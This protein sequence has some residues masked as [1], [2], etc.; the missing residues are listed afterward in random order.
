MPLVQVKGNQCP[1]CLDENLNWNLKIENSDMFMFGCG[2][3]CCKTCFPKLK[4]KEAF[5]CPCCREDGHHTTIS[6]LGGKRSSWV[7]FDEWF[8]EFEIYIMSGCAKNVI[9]NSPFGKQLI[10]LKKSVKNK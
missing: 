9:K 4:E 3:G 7:T 5:T 1:I 8:N 2:H 6:F 10:R